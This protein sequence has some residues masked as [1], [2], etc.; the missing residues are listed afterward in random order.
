MLDEHQITFRVRYPDCDPMGV[1]HHSRFFQYFEMG[2]IELLRASG[3]SY[4]ELEMAGVLFV[5][6]KAECRYRAPARFDDEVTLITRVARRTHVR[7][8][9][10]YVL[11]R[12][13][14]V[15]AE[16]LTTIACVDRQGQLREIPE[17]MLKGGTDG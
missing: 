6:V 2:R 12:G 11:K 4:A 7:I 3:A 13:A 16:A 8:D 5:V 9:H 1:V 14:T 10:E 15:L 17:E